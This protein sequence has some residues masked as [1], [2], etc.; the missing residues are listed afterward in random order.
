MGLPAAATW[1]FQPRAYEQFD[2]QRPQAELAPFHLDAVGL[3][4]AAAAIGPACPSHQPRVKAARKSS[5]PS[6]GTKPRCP[7]GPWYSKPQRARKTP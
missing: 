3:P 2:G 4:A 1:P 6:F 5:A 7:S